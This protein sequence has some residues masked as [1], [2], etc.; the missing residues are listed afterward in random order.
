MRD[1]EERTYLRTDQYG[2]GASLRARIALHRRFSTAMTSWHDWVYARL[3]GAIDAVARAVLEV[4][5][6]TGAL[7]AGRTIPAGWDVVLT[8]LSVGMT[9]EA[10]RVAG[11]GVR[12]VAADAAELPFADECF[13]GVVANH[14]LY[15]VPDRRRALDE[16]R[17]V[18]RPGGLLFAATNGRDHMRELDEFVRE[19]ASDAPSLVGLPADSFLL[20]TGADALARRF[21]D[22]R[23]SVYADGLVVTEPDPLVAYVLSSTGDE[24]FARD[25]RLE[26]LRTRA[27]QVTAGRGF[28]VTKSVGLFTARKEDR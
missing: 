4:G 15:H 2:S 20:A 17:R 21:G 7:W 24:P 3:V 6:G 25:G 12:V 13:D 16:F 14:M 5:C 10:R 28:A 18:L 9:T 23:C 27:H 1:V 26:R 8:D 19:V 22:V 11:G